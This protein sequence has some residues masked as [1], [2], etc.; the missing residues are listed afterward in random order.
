MKGIAAIVGRPNV[1]KSTLFNRLIEKRKAIV[2]A[3]DGVTRDRL[4]GNVEWSGRQFTVID[5][6]GIMIHPKDHIELN[7]R[8]QALIAV[9]EADVILFMVDVITGPTEFD[10]EI[11][12]ILKK[13]GKPVILCVNKV[14]MPER[15]LD[16][17]IFYKLGIGEPYFM[18]ALGGRAIG[19]ILDKVLDNLP[20]EEGFDVE[21]HDLRFALLGMPNSGKS[22]MANTFLEQERHIVTDIPGTTRD[23]ISSTFK[24]QKKKLMI[25]DTAGI[26]KRNI[27]EDQIEFYSSVRSLK[28]INE[29]HVC[30]FIVDGTKGFGK[31][32]IKIMNE[33][34]SR[35]K[36]LLVAV[37]KWDAVEKDTHTAKAILD[38]MIYL[39]PPLRHY[40][41][42]FVSATEKQRLFKILDEALLIRERLRTHV[43]TSELNDYF[44]GVMQRHPIPSKN[45]RFIKIKFIN[46]LAEEPPVIAFYANDPKA[47]EDSYKRFLEN[48]FR[49]GFNFKGVP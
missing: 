41:V 40:P 43:K 4:Y 39:F 30:I 37:N 29:S 15:E 23:A 24:Y 6:G 38:N 8:K 12:G 22:T 19:D 11:A 7:I 26:R 21:E 34:I 47:I 13:A 17:H 45:G 10:M 14:D 16:I 27:Y 46:Q 42:Y 2:D 9:G 48:E 20:S 31:G 44:Q 49:K 18:S 5:T 36:G 32:D 3:E 35:G 28:A 1:G 33:V 25:V